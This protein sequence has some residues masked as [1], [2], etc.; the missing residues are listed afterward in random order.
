MKIAIQ[1]DPIEAVDVDADTSFDMALEA[2]GRGH[3]IWVYQPQMLQLDGGSVRA[4][5]RKVEHL[6]RDQGEHVKLAAPEV[7]DLR[8]VDVVL[9]R[10]DPPF[11]MAYITAAQILERLV[12][13]VLVLNNP[14]S[15]RDAPEKLFVTEFA[16]LTPPTLITR[17]EAAMRAFR[18]QHG[19]VIVKPLYGNGGAGVFKLS[20]D[21]GNFNALLELFAEAYE[22]PAII[23]KFLPDVKKGDKRIIL[24]D[25][26]AV[27]AI[28]RVPAKGETRSNMHVGG[29]AEAAEMNE[30]DQEICDRIGPV[31][32]E[33]GLVFAG[34]DVIGDYLTEI[35]VTSPTG[36]QEVRRFGGAD[37][38]ALFIDW[39]EG[40]RDA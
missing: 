16:D 23:Q 3:E 8:G 33:R 35:N 31:L 13:D 2:F 19:D 11:N 27:G 18:E 9:V 29:R 32:A 26:E 39:I 21:D 36:V 17:D 37:I 22:E 30:R 40:Q 34:I 24:L 12:P 28:N 1:M 6:K 5:A 10:Q 4:R 15:I 38:S 25:G 14:R 20:S 7:I